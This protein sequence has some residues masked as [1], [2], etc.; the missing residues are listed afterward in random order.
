MTLTRADL[1]EYD[2]ELGIPFTAKQTAQMMLLESR[3]GDAIWHDNGATIQRLAQ[4][5]DTP[6]TYIHVDLT[7]LTVEY[8]T[9]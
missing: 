6:V 9:A 1:Q 5:A 3:D 4:T 2:G 8:R 7:T